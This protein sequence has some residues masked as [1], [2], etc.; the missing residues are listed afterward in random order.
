MEKKII[1]FISKDAEYFSADKSEFKK[2]VQSLMQISPFEVQVIDVL[3]HPE[4]AEKY[5]IA[6]LPTLIINDHYYVGKPSAKKAIEIFHKN[7]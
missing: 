3:E 7:T 1:L 4:M 6:A 5:K 2:I